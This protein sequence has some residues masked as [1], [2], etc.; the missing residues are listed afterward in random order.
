MVEVQDTFSVPFISFLGPYL[1]FF[2][3][4]IMK[5]DIQSD[6][7]I[8]NCMTFLKNVSE[9]SKYRTDEKVIDENIKQA[10][11]IL[12]AVFTKENVLNICKVLICTYFP[13]SKEELQTWA[14]DPETYFN[15]DEMDSTEERVKVNQ[16][17][18]LFIHNNH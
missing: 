12:D 3:T 15:D 4:R 2:F 9:C 5:N 17:S 7:F 8:I 18:V 10:N 11:N 13:I 16:F 14:S 6:R 1:Q